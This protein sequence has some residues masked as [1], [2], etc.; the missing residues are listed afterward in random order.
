VW[1]ESCLTV[2]SC[3][4]SVI[5]GGGGPNIL[6]GGGGVSTIFAKP[7]FQAGVTGLSGANREVPDVALNAA[8]FHDSTAICVA[9]QQ[10]NPNCVPVNNQFSVALVG[11]TSVAAPS[12]AGIMALVNQ[13]TGSRQGE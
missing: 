10:S 12:F 4:A 5:A 13:V 2:G 8:V 1:N 11:G 6:S 3:L 9:D 7:A